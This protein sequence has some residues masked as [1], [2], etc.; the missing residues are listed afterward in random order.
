MY[1]TEPIEKMFTLKL[2]SFNVVNTSEVLDTHK[3]FG[4]LYTILKLFQQY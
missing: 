3:S 2:I 1:N 4:L